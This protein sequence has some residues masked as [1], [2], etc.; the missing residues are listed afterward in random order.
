MTDLHYKHL[1][2]SVLPAPAAGAGA[3][4]GTAPPSDSS[5]NLTR[6]ERVMASCHAVSTLLR[7]WPGIAHFCGGGDGTAVKSLIGVLHAPNREMTK[8]VVD[9]LFAIFDIPLPPEGEE[10]LLKAVSF[11]ADPSKF[12]MRHSW[13][14]SAG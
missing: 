3:A 9:L 2:E 8:N 13:R 12:A 7:A 5:S 10:D 1:A 11:I 4:A 14:I 6:A